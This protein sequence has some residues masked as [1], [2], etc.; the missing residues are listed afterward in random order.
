M[1]NFSEYFLKLQLKYQKRK[2]YRL[3]AK[4]GLASL[5]VL[6]Q[7]LVVDVLINRVMQRRIK[8]GKYPN[9]IFS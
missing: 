6:E 5:E 2:M 7:S 1:C 8:A 3:T 9:L 4:Y